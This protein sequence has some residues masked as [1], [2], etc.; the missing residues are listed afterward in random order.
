[1]QKLWDTMKKANFLIIGRVEEES[2]VTGTDQIF[3]KITDKS[4]SKSRSQ[5][6]TPQ[7]DIRSEETLAR[8]SK[9][10]AG[11]ALSPLLPLSC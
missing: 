5:G 7:L 2:Q 10:L 1:M 4:I 9:A 3:N 11:L 8:V 6:K